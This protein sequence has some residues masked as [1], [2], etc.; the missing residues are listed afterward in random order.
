M[1][2]NCGTIYKMISNNVKIAILSKLNI[3]MPDKQ[4][5]MLQLS[6]KKVYYTRNYCFIPEKILVQEESLKDYY[7]T[8]CLV[9]KIITTH[10]AE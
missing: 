1:V 2:P 3:K 5:L 9:L 10:L 6:V 8:N 7:Y 4:I